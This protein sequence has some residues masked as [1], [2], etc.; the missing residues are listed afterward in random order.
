[1]CMKNVLGVVRTYLHYKYCLFKFCFF[2]GLRSSY[3]A[4]LVSYGTAQ[5]QLDPHTW[6]ASWPTV[7]RPAESIQIGAGAHQHPQ[8]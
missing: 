4:I 3:Y 1:M 7:G 8:P 2:E 6:V 5:R